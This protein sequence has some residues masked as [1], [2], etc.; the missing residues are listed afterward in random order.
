MD[1]C[2]EQE[3]NFNIG[4]NLKQLRS[5]AGLTQAEVAARLQVM[6][7]PV[8]REI[9]A[10][11]ESGKHHIKIRILMALREIYKASYEE[12]FEG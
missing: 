9:Y 5:R 1:Q 3:Q 8:S 7:L 4:N 2:L 6:G 12:L 11:I 10:Q